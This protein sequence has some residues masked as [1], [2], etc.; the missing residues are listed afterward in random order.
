MTYAEFTTHL[1]AKAGQ[2]RRSEDVIFIL[3]GREI[4]RRFHLTEVLAVTVRSLDCGGQV[5]EWDEVVLQLVEPQSIGGCGN[6]K[7][8]VASGDTAAGSNENT[9]MTLEKLQRILE[10]SNE[11][12]GIDRS[13]RVLVEYRPRGVS[14][15]Q[16]YLVKELIW[17]DSHLHI[18]G[19]GAET[20]CK[21]M[22]RRQPSCCAP[23]V[24]TCC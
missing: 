7:T 1:M 2:P 13:G 22:D 18:V 16:R 3:D 11:L 12:L 10:Q 19:L 14:A 4:D 6:V 15:V 17:K 20:Q 8:S 9:N 24:K 21:A 5:D 23:K